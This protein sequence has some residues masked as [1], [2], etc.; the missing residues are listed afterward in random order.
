MKLLVVLVLFAA[1]ACALDC[2]QKPR[3]Q[4]KASPSPETLNSC[5][6]YSCNSCCTADTTKELALKPLQTVGKWN[7]A[8]CGQPLSDACSMSFSDI[9]CLYKCSPNIYTFFGAD[10]KT[11]TRIPLC[12]WFCDRWYQTCMN[13]MTCVM[14]Q[15]WMTGFK[16]VNRTDTCSPGSSCR[17]FTQVYAGGKNMCDNLFG[18][19]FKFSNDSGNCLDPFSPSHNVEIIQTRFP[20]KETSVCEKNTTNYLD[21]GAIVGIVFGVLAAIFLILLGVGFYLKRKN[22]EDLKVK[23]PATPQEMATMT[24]KPVSQPASGPPDS[25]S[26]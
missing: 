3:G 12:S 19:T 21:A 18:Q 20:G 25:D 6:Q 7:F 23:E 5:K 15:S 4:H 10:L 17:N 26:D 13:D 9:M 2:P 24:T 1:S 14:N 16:L 22:S 8:Q 11:L